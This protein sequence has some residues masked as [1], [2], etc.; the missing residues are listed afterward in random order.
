MGAA[1]AEVGAAVGFCRKG[2][3]SRKGLALQPGHTQASSRKLFCQPGRQY[4]GNRIGIQLVV[5]REQ[6][7]ACFVLLTQNQ[8]SV[9]QVVQLITKK[10]FDESTL[11]LHQKHFYQTTGELPDQGRLQRMNH[12]HLEQTNAITAQV[13]VCQAQLAQGLVEVI[14]GL[15]CRHQSDPILRGRNSD[16]VEVIFRGKEPGCFQSAKLDFTF[17]L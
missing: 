13:I 1:R 17:H 6:E 3:Q 5:G 2:G 9:G 4:P 11:L 7:L 8:R 16:L 14:I 15:A 10:E 12:P